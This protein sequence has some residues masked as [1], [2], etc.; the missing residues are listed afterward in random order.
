MR[1]SGG[2]A[3]GIQLVAPKGD[4]TRPATDG[5]RQGVFSSLG[6]AVVGARFL[7]CSRAAA[8]MGWRP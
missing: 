3:R 7:D 2:I 8:R 6:A 5:M 1:I 4:A